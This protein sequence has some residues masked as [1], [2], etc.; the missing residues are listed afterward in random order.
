MYGAVRGET[1][2]GDGPA[3]AHVAATVELE[4]WPRR[5]ST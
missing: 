4:G 1:G 2:A 5:A 3:E